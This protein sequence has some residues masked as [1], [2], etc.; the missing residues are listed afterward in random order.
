MPSNPFT[1]ELDRTSLT[2]PHLQPLQLGAF[3]LAGG[4]APCLEIPLDRIQ[5]PSVQPRVAP[6]SLQ[7]DPS[8]GAKSFDQSTRVSTDTG[9]VSSEQRFGCEQRNEAKRIPRSRRSLDHGAVKRSLPKP[10]ETTRGPRGK[11]LPA[12]LCCGAGGQDGGCHVRPALG[13]AELAP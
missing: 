2:S 3:L 13:S 9:H 4:C 7:A 1:R 12:L 10:A 5:T 11:D 8:G 6:V